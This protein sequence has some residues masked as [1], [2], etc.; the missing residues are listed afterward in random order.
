MAILNPVQ[1]QKHLGGLDYPVSKEDLIERAQ[2]E[3]ADE[4]VMNLLGQLPDREYKIA[5]RPS[6]RKQPG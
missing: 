2:K 4:E 3:G 6:P 5:P 1:L